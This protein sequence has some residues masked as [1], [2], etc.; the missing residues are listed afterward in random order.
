LSFRIILDDPASH[1]SFDHVCAVETFLDG[2][3]DCVTLHQISAFADTLMDSLDVH[4][5]CPSQ[6]GATGRVLRPGDD[7]AWDLVIQPD[8]RI[9][10]AGHVNPGGFALLRLMA[11]GTPDP[12]FGVGG[13]VVTNFGLG[14]TNGEARA[15]ILQP[16]GRLVAAGF[17]YGAPPNVTDVAM[18]RYLPDGALDTSFGSAGTVVTTVAQRAFEATAL[19]LRT[20]GRLV[21]AGTTHEVDATAYGYGFFLAG[22]L[23]EKHALALAD[24][25]EVVREIGTELSADHPRAP[26]M[27][28]PTAQQ[29]AAGEEA[30][31]VD[32]PSLAA[33]VDRIDGNI[34]VILDMLQSIV[35]PS[36]RD[37]H[38]AKSGGS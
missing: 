1:D 3:L 2:M 7:Y 32:F 13:T 33:T 27:V 30:V 17:R 29:R 34:D 9:V 10:A 24:V 5:L 35:R 4:A 20:D 38:G 6:I 22:Y 15:L 23:A 14:P 31:S 28:L 21:V 12:S 18:A 11:N 19:A 36:G 8:G 16:D 37:K 26:V 25:E